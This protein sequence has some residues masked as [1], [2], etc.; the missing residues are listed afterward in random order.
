MLK[1]LFLLEEL[2]TALVV[3]DMEEKHKTL[4]LSRGCGKIQAV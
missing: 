2:V 3:A 4:N 1:A